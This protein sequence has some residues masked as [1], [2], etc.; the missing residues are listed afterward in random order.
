MIISDY[1]KEKYY[2]INSGQSNVIYTNRYIITANTADVLTFD[3]TIPD[4]K[5]LFIERFGIL[6]RNISGVSVLEFPITA[7]IY[8]CELK[9]DTDV[10]IA[11]DLPNEKSCI[12]FLQREK[13]VNDL[14]PI[15]KEIEGDGVKKLQLRITNGYAGDMEVYPVIKGRM[16]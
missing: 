9:F 6:L 12:Y 8:S 13:N 11:K 1:L 15:L 7:V 16:I 2:G 14:I 5:K 10:I 3:I 4:G